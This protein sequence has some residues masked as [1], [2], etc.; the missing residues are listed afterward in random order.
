MS[1]A[2]RIT[3]HPIID[4]VERREIP[5]TFNGTKLTA[6]EGEVISS[7]L[8]ANGVHEFGHHPRDGSPQGIFCVNGQCSQCL[9]IADGVPVKACMTLVRKDIDVR[10]CEGLPSLPEFDE[11]VSFEEVPQFDTEVL[12][13]G[14]GPAG[15][16]ASIELGKLGLNVILI[17]D[18]PALGGK[19]TLQTH[20]FFGSR[21]DCFAGTRGID[22]AELLSR[23]LAE[24]SNVEV[25]TQS[26]AVG[27]FLDRK[28]G[29]L[30]SGRYVLVSPKILLVACGAREKSLGFVGCDL[31]GVYGAGAF[32][33]LANRDLVRPAEKLFVVGGGNVGLIGSYHAL[34]AGIKVAG[35]CEALPE[36]T[37]YKVHLDKIR[38][39]GVSVFTSHTVVRAE[40]KGRVT[41]VTIARCGKD[42]KPIAGTEKS[43][44][45][46]TIL[47]A[48]GLSSVNELFL[49][50]K[51]CGMEVYAAGD[52]E[53]IAE[54]SAAIFSGK[55]LG[56]KIARRLNVECDIPPEWEGL[57]CVL[58]SKPGPVHEPDAPPPGLLRFPVI[59]CVQEIPCNPCT[60]VCPKKAIF[61]PGDSLMGRPQFRRACLGCARCV[62]GC[63]GLA[64]VMVELDYDPEGKVALLT[65]PFEF[66]EEVIPEGKQVET[67]DFEGKRLG[68]GTVVAVKNNPT[69]NR[70]RLVLL[71]VPYADALS[72]A[73]IRIQEEE[74]PIPGEICADTGKVGASAKTASIEDEDIIICRCE[75]VGRKAIVEQLRAGVRDM[76][77]LKAVLRPGMGSCGGKTCR[78]LILGICREEGIRLSE[79]TP[80][81]YR[82]FEAEVPLAAFCG[83]KNEKSGG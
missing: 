55:L 21:T 37:G 7:A 25:W 48:V 39:L 27:V 28:V 10:S 6:K 49:Q 79:V 31:P 82:P 63:P 11:P 17:D 51:E 16:C 50:A 33:T 40:G 34:Q 45:V 66:S 38:R 70:C 19:L 64:I 12:V 30:R 43:F 3:N 69:Q 20:Q 1:S 71:E 9:V 23:Q 47:I 54:A 74:S 32:Q 46:D 72:V 44:K 75:R 5:F 61:I 77:H 41:G 81:T 65:V 76:N 18:K 24:L 56:R 4:V 42:F 26:L 15:L 8:F 14:A 62:A 36:C 59:R 2:A 58:R 78:E 68:H 83:C 29:V 57:A 52:S 67:A 53:E 60:K 80:S 73:G 22:I 35:L 13:I